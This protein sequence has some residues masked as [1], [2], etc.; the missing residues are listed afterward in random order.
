[1]YPKKSGMERVQFTNLEKL[2]EGK[3]RWRSSHV[4]IVLVYKRHVQNPLFV[5]CAMHFWPQGNS[6]VPMSF[7][8]I[9]SQV[10]LGE[11]GTIVKLPLAL[12]GDG[13]EGNFTKAPNEVLIPEK[14]IHTAPS[15]PPLRIFKIWPILT[16]ARHRDPRKLPQILRKKTASS[17][18]FQPFFVLP[19][20]YK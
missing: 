18:D 11:I 4:L 1:M 14:P 3:C 13:H 10:N 2:H 6:D 12:L 5:I 16:N 19:R 17:N 15:M 9:A 8:K 20:C 7:T